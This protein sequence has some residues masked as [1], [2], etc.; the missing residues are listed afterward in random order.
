MKRYTFKALDGVDARLIAGA[1][2]YWASM[3]YIGFDQSTTAGAESS[4][5]S[6]YWASIPIA[7]L[8][9][10]LATVFSRLFERNGF[11]VDISFVVLFVN[12]TSFV[13]EVGFVPFS[14]ET[15]TVF[16][17]LTGCSIAA[18][19][20]LWGFAFASLDKRTAG[21]NVAVTALASVF[22]SL[23]LLLASA[24]LD[25]SLD[26]LKTI[27]R[28]LSALFLVAGLVR[29]S[30]IHRERQV[31]SGTA[32]IRFYASRVLIGV[33]IGVL[34]GTNV[35]PISP[36]MVVVAA[37]AVFSFMLFCIRAKDNLYGF[38]PVMPLVLAGLLFLPFFD[39]GS[40]ALSKIASTVIWLVWIFLSSFQLSGLKETFGLSETRLCFSEK[41][42]V[43]TGW[44][45]GMVAAGPLVA[46]A[47]VDSLALLVVYAALLFATFSSFRTV[48]N[49]KE[50]EHA[51]QLIR[52]REERFD[53][54]YNG[55]ADTYGLTK[56]EREVMELLAQGYTRTHIGKTLFVSDGTARSH[57]AHVYRKLDIHK[58]DDLLKLVQSWGVRTFFRTA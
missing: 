50:D 44:L 25:V 39:E 56:R 10:V 21:K 29:F 37:V 1:S 22:L 24:A 28:A 18:L 13:I 3:L 32:L 26:V 19:V 38:L 40:R 42:V 57:I 23:V 47:G 5:D 43:L 52:A 2:L 15:E 49:A 30:N 33:G 27:A 31:Q 14:P 9:A 48:Y 55:I 53:T 6:W 41:A 4:F 51:E 58:K 45:V 54:I 34:G 12:A 8:L 16:S 17:L 46:C 7:T 11:R 36:T 20:L 35:G